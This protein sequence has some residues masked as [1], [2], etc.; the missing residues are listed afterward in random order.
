MDCAKVLFA[1]IRTAKLFASLYIFQPGPEQTFVT[2]VM[3]ALE[4]SAC[5]FLKSEFIIAD[6]TIQFLVG[7]VRASLI[8][9]L[10]EGLETEFI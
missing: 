8:C 5:F 1:A 3:L 4:L 6:R 2:E 9:N 10:L 7:V